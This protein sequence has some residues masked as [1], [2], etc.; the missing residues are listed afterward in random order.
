MK[1]ASTTCPPTLFATLSPELRKSI[2]KFYLTI[3]NLVRMF[4]EKPKP[5]GLRQH[6]N[7]RPSP[8][9]SGAGRSTYQSRITAYFLS[10][11]NQKASISQG[12]KSSNP[13]SFQQH[14]PAESLSSCRPAPASP[15][16]S[17]F[18]PY[19]KANI[20]YI[21][22]QSRF[23]SR[24]SFLQSRSSFAWPRFMSPPTFSP[25][26][27]SPSPDHVCCTCFGHSSFLNGLFNYRRPSQQHPWNRRPMRGI[28][29]R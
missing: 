3:D 12:L 25:S 22:L 21:L 16:K 26:F 13:K 4:A 23:S 1:T 29:E 2:S 11:A 9:S 15:E 18:S 7:R 20:F 8:Q 6:Q 24:F 27:R 10:S 19:K 14:T 5:F 28:W 17:A